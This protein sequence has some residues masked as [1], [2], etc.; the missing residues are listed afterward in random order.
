M[1]LY[2]APVSYLEIIYNPRTEADKSMAQDR[3]F[4]E[5]AKYLR[6]LRKPIGFFGPV[7]GVKFFAIQKIFGLGPSKLDRNIIGFCS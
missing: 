2:I 6:L 7:R 1:F 4:S 5:I 3:K